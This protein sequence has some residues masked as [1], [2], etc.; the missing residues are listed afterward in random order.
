MK[1]LTKQEEKAIIGNIIE[2]ELLAFKSL[3][4][5]YGTSRA[6]FNYGKD[7]V[8]KIALDEGGITQNKNEVNFVENFGDECV[9]SIFGYSDNI[10]IA[11]KLITYDLNH[12][13]DAYC[14]FVNDGIFDEDY[15]DGGFS[16][17]EL[18]DLVDT[19]DFL[20]SAI[21]YTADNYQLGQDGYG[22][23]KA[24]D[25]GYVSKMGFNS[26]VGEVDRIIH[27]GKLITELDFLYYK[28]DEERPDDCEF[29]I[30]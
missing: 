12:I 17:R 22:K 10:L 6:V 21:D 16:N 24:Y 13:E 11:E 20:N 15:S 18:E 29:E 4:L 28:L 27:D 9:A 7:K 3:L 1:K 2:K 23:F 14:Y 8:V 26:Q 5:G 30:E 25:Y 19:V